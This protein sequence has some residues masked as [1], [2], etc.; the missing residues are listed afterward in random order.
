MIERYMPY[1]PSTASCTDILSS[2]VGPLLILLSLDKRQKSTLS[3]REF[4]VT[5]FLSHME[6]PRNPKLSFFLCYFWSLFILFFIVL[7]IQ[8]KAF[9][10]LSKYST[11]E[12]YPQPLNYVSKS[13]IFIPFPLL[14]PNPSPAP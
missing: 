10:M 7:R 5:S 11:T 3:L 9:L 1:H 6:E 4:S 2:S 14:C 13:K 8:P 12:L